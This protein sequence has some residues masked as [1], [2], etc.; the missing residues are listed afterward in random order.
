MKYL[1]LLSM[2]SVSMVF[3][4]NRIL[5]GVGFS[6]FGFFIRF[7]KSVHEVIKEVITGI[8]CNRFIPESLFFSGLTE[9][10]LN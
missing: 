6:R 3:R 2:V 8:H 9:I 7:H 5:P 4:N 1:I 10:T